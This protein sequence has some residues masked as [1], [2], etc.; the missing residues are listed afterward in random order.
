MR[1]INVYFCIINY[2]EYIQIFNA[3]LCGSPVAKP[4]AEFNIG[5][6]KIKLFSCALHKP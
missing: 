6:R 1:V 2:C 5:A 4:L 3:D